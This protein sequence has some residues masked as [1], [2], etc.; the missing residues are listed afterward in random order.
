MWNYLFF[1]V[2]GM[3]DKPVSVSWLSGWSPAD[4]LGRTHLENPKME[5]KREGEELLISLLRSHIPIFLIYINQA[6]MNA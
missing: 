2:L 3:S 4:T 6:S 1:I 5:H